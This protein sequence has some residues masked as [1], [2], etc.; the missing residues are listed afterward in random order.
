MQFESVQFQTSEVVNVTLSGTT[1]KIKAP[2]ARG[3]H[4]G[5]VSRPPRGGNSLYFLWVH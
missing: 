4:P 5:P 2:D 3:Q 1:A